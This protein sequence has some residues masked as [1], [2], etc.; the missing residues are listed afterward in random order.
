M[1]MLFSVVPEGSA[2]PTPIPELRPYATGANTILRT[3]VSPFSH[4]PTGEVLAR[5]GRKTLVIAGFATKAVVLQAALDARVAGYTVYC[6]LD[7]MGSP[8]ERTENAAV[9]EIESADGI[10]TSVLSLAT[11]LVNDLVSPPGA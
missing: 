11:R 4:P 8:S 10:S 6:V 5:S 1:P 9:R 2:P 7:A 3:P